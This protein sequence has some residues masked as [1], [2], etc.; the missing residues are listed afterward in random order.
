MFGFGHLFD[1]GSMTA[2]VPDFLPMKTVVVMLTGVVIVA[3]GLMVLLGYRAKLAGKILFVFMFV[4]AISVWS[5]GF[6]DGDQVSTA[7]FMKDLAL[8]GA[9]L[10]IAHF[11]AGPMSMDAK[12]EA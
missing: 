8:S 4:T 7:M 6:M 12:A 11:G 1:A 3:G 9:S 2:I 5:G 10:M